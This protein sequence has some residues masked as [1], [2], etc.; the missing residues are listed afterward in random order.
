MGGHWPQL[1]ADTGPQNEQTK[2]IALNFLRTVC[3]LGHGVSF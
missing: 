1:G 3:G 2:H